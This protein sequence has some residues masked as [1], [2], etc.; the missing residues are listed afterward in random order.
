MPGVVGVDGLHRGRGDRE[1]RHQRR[2]H[3][4][5]PARHRAGARAAV[6]GL[7]A[8]D[9]GREARYLDA[10]GPRSRRRPDR[11]CRG[12]GSRQG[13]RSRRRRTGSGP[14]R[15]SLPGILLGEELFQH[16]LRVFVGSEV[17]VACPMCG[18]GPTGPDAQAR[19]RSAWPG[20]STRHVRVRFQA[21]VRRRCATRR[22]SWAWQGEVTGIEIRTTDPGGRDRA[23]P[24]RSRARA[25]RRTTRCARGR[26]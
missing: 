6:L 21:G 22:S 3:G 24:T 9:E 4:H 25:G 23:S 10:P 13:R 15:A 14:R 19:S 1:A 2:R 5:H 8:H 12:D 7:G 17:D 18:V 11:D 16:I 26:S 20:T